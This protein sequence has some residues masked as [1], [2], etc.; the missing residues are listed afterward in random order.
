MSVEKLRREAQRWHQQGIDDLEAATALLTASK[1]PQA[2]FYAQQAAE[3][4]LK[5]VWF[6]LDLDPWGHSCGRLIRDLPDPVKKDFLVL[7]DTALALDKLYIPTR[8]PDAL[9]EL[10]PSEAFT[11]SEAESAIQSGER[12]I[13]QVTNWLSSTD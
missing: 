8:Y 11:R 4:A 13:Q 12:L 5:A 2:C 7:M 6:R 1:Y 10:T 9:A 3:K